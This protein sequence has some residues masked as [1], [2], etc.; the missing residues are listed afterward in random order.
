MAFAAF[1]F[2]V[3]GCSSGPRLHS[4]SG[5][6]TLDGKPLPGASVTFY[7]EGP[8]Q[9]AACTSDAQGRYRP[10]TGNNQGVYNGKY[11]VTVTKLDIPNT[12]GKELGLAPESR[13][14][15]VPAKFA[16]K[17]SSDLKFEVPAGVYDIDLK[18]K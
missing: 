17:D 1:A 6:V 9:A 4:V 16:S 13:K 7:P 18:S 15:L 12:G 3:I 11:T 14:N 8:G 5:V 2:A 10:E